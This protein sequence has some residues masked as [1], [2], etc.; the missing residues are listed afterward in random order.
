[1]TLWI[2]L[3]LDGP[4]P[5]HR[6]HLL[7][8]SILR[9]IY[10]DFLISSYNCAKFLWYAAENNALPSSAES[11]ADDSVSSSN[12]ISE[13]SNAATNLLKWIFDGTKTKVMELVEKII[14][15]DIKKKVFKSYF[16]W[17]YFIVFNLISISIYHHSKVPICWALILLGTISIVVL[18]FYLLLLYFLRWKVML[19][20]KEIW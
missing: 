7:W 18:L 2:W 8:L 10:M 14:D 9:C 17:I 13:H 6:R 3:Y 15:K 19:L 11:F 16:L 20:R 1:M 5:R 12:G 4:A